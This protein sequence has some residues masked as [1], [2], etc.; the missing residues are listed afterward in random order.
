MCMLKCRYMYPEP[1]NHVTFV[2]VL[3]RLPCI[4]LQC[5]DKVTCVLNCCWRMVQVLTCRCVVSW[6]KCQFSFCIDRYSFSCQCW[7]FSGSSMQ[8]SEFLKC[9]SI[10]VFSARVGGRH[11]I[12]LP[13]MVAVQELK[14]F[15]KVVKAFFSL[16]CSLIYVVHI[17]L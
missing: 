9:W 7:E 6:W 3:H 15:C 12:M 8:Y 11:F 1:H 13:C 2:L 16:P 10:F 4:M 17:H 14:L 5:Q